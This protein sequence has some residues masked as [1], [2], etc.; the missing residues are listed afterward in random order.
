MKICCVGNMSGGKTSLI[1]RLL[2]ENLKELSS[3]IGLDYKVLR[4]NNKKIEFWDTAGQER[5][6]SLAPLYLRGS[7][8]TLLVVDV[9]DYSLYD[10]QYWRDFI[11]DN[12]N[13]SLIY[14]ILNKCDL[15]KPSKVDLEELEELFVQDY[16]KIYQ[17]SCLKNRGI[18][19][20]LEDLLKLTLENKDPIDIYLDE[21]IPKKPFWKCW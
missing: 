6:R 19:K 7:D 8:I 4:Q 1:R 3:T 16:V 2:G 20:L 15:K 11:W 17:T 13:G 9:S 21:T 5:Y 14:L 18:T 10:I 12:S